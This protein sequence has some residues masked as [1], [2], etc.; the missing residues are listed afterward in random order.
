MTMECVRVQ[1]HAAVRGRMWFDNASLLYQA[2]HTLNSTEATDAYMQS[3]LVAWAEVLFTLICAVID[4]NT[5][6]L[7]RFPWS[8]KIVLSMLIRKILL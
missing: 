1:V 4:Q 5:Y 6:G 7:T 2:M 3:F 8:K